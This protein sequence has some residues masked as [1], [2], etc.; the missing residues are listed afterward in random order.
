M[1]VL[2]SLSS[3]KCFQKLSAE[4]RQQVERACAWRTFEDGQMIL[5]F[6]DHSREVFFLVSGKA[7]SIIYAAS[8]RVVAFGDQPAGSMFG[9]IGAIDGK[10]RAVAVEALST[11]TVATLSHQ[12]FLELATSEPEFTLALLQ[13]IVANLRMLTARIFEYSTLTVNDRIRA[14]LLRLAEQRHADAAGLP[15]MLSP[16]PKHSDI[17]ARVSTQREAVTR[18]LN[19]LIKLGVLGKHGSAIVIADVVRLRQMVAEANA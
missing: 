18:E 12:D 17:A 19:H 9:E 6:Q 11:S 2:R 10:P 5:N 15:I 4:R 7:R 8:G 14:E 16:S 3:I 1:T 13:Q